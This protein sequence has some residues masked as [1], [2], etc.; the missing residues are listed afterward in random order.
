MRAIHP[1][2]T[3]GHVHLIVANLERSLWFYHEMIGFQVLNV[4][5]KKATLTADGKTSLVVL[6][7]QT[8]AIRKPRRTTGLY[9]FAILVPERKSLAQV[10]LHLL[11][12]GYPLQGASDH[13]FSEAIYLADPDG[14]GI[15]IYA[16]RP[17][18]RWE[19]TESGEYKGV[20][21][22]LDIQHL[23]AEAED[24]PWKG[25]PSATT[26]GHVH[27]HVANMEETYRF[28]VE[29]LGFEPVIRMGDHALFV[30]AGGYHHHIGLNTWA[31]VGAPKPPEN[32]VGL[33]VFSI[34]LPNDEERKKVIAQ[35]QQ[36]GAVIHE[37]TSV[38]TVV[39]PAGNQLELRIA[40]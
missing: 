24:E 15:E 19:K 22:P 5:N 21:E 10:L 9:H 39:D 38:V 35:L 32:A 7:E 12:N 28:Y 37:E 23:L 30:S 3:I 31:G 14:N 13:L 11:K 8:N 33:R 34:V 40:R 27:L 2:T 18:E 36:I 16:D 29:G 4:S 6:E 1:E 17:R 25:L 20:S 26:I